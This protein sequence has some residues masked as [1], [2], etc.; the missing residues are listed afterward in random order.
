M[1]GKIVKFTEE[2]G[3]G[4]IVDETGEKLPFHVSEVDKTIGLEE[5]VSV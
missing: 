2:N 3:V 1:K 5:G 4:F